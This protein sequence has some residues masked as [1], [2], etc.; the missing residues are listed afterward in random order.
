VTIHVRA[1]TAKSIISVLLITVL[2]GSLFA[3]P[4]EPT[5][6]SSLTNLPPRV[7][8]SI[9]IT[10]I[11]RSLITAQFN[12]EL[13][14]AI[15]PADVWMVNTKA[16]GQPPGTPGIYVQIAGPIVFDSWVNSTGTLTSGHTEQLQIQEIATNFPD[17]SAHIVLFVGSNY[18]IQ[19]P[20]VS[21]SIPTYLVEEHY[22]DMKS[23]GLP[24][25]WKSIS[26]LSQLYNDSSYVAT[27]DVYIQHSCGFRTFAYVAYYTPFIV[28]A[29]AFLLTVLDMI[30]PSKKGSTDYIQGFLTL[31]LFVPIFSFGISQLVPQGDSVFLQAWL[32]FVAYWTSISFVIIVIL[33]FAVTIRHFV[34]DSS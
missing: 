26:Y 34:K 11:N 14:N 28:I 23:T 25:E 31:L 20:I 6:A 22:T 10:Q 12:V 7:I 15:R 33:T 17:D 32:S 9:D 1:A 3:W 27:F 24:P 30:R 2:V 18:S 16:E 29:I 19:E 13:V 4:S 8:T 5:R 21:S